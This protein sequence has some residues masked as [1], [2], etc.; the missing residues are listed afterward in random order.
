MTT[1]AFDVVNLP[2]NE[3]RFIAADHPDLYYIGR[4][5][6]TTPQ[7]PVFVWQGSELRARFS[8]QRIGFRFAEPQGQNFYNV[9]IDGSVH[10]L[11]LT[12]AGTHDYLLAVTLPPGVHELVLFKR[13]EALFGQATFQGL[14]LE[15][16][17]RMETKPEP[18]PLRIEFY[19]DSI[20][21]GACNEDTDADQY[22]D[23]VTH[24][25]YLAYGALTARALN[26]EYVCIAVS[27]TGICYSWNPVLL[28]E[29]FDRTN[30]EPGSPRYAF[31]ER[32][33]DL[34]VI[35]LGQN[36]YGFTLAEGIAFPA[37]FT[38]KYREFVRMIRNMYPAAHIICAIG[39][40][41]AYRD[42]VQLRTAFSQAVTELAAEDSRMHSFVFTAF[43]EN[44][45]R[46]T[47]HR[48]LADELTGF[49]K[50][51]VLL[52]NQTR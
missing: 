28:P 37:D 50:N 3:W 19:G 52:L 20:T 18:L 41:T 49:I 2:K 11:Q 29:V 36:D 33:P 45:P 12:P 5:D 34:V 22:D 51:E 38:E 40:M 15:L 14:I 13:T 1:A 9:T 35:N 21:A 10:Q 43:A 16:T 23:L 6:R 17:A 46:L 26:A 27:G 31:T 8:G 44:H 7:A 48:Q 25:N 24:N 47:V 32:Q 30:P 4:I 39:G 42:S